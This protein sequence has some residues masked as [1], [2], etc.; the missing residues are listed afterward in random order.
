MAHAILSPSAAHRWSKCPASVVL[1]R[2]LESESSRDAEE[3][4]LAHEL[5]ASLLMSP[6]ARR[7]CVD[8]GGKIPRLPDA[9]R[10]DLAARGFDAEG[11][12]ADVMQYVDFVATLPQIQIEQPIK[13]GDVLDEPGCFGTADAVSDTSAG[14][15]VCDLKMGRRPVAAKD[16]PQLTLYAAGILAASMAKTKAK[17][18]QSL[19]VH[20]VIVQPRLGV[21][22]AWETTARDVMRSAAALAK[23]GARALELAG[24][25]EMLPAD[26]AAGDHC[27]FCPAAATCRTLASVATS[28]L[29]ANG[30]AMSAAIR[31]NSAEL[32]QA[33]Q[34]LPM[35]KAW[36]DA[37]ARETL[38]RLSSGVHLPG[39]YLG[40]GKAGARCWSDAEAAEK[41]AVEKFG[42]AAYE[43]RALKSP[44]QLEKLLKGASA[45]EKKAFADMVLRPE[46]SPKVLE[47]TPPADAVSEAVSFPDVS[48]EVGT[49]APA[50]T[51]TTGGK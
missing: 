46:G 43:P 15:W 42:D 22:D 19:P 37:V 29:P 14:L 27:R 40:R 9:I 2:L 28:A 3:G 21:L 24:G 51:E 49:A 34:R 33:W 7:R 6:V 35:I 50:Q 1:S 31:L 13:L 44:T 30:D 47:G 45:E 38:S 11:V 12:E 26:F 4:T 16:N 39:L 41:W 17:R 32:V 23:A 20:L 5:A 48:A 10:A 36:A 25:A 8:S 18:P